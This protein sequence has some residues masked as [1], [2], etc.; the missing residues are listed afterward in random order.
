MGSR[1]S[2]EELVQTYQFSTS[3]H[4]REEAAKEAIRRSK[5]EDKATDERMKKGRK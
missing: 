4:E 3:K 1:K 5:E 2:D